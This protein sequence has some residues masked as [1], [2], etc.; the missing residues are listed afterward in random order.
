MK[1]ISDNQQIKTN[2]NWAPK[3]SNVRNQ[4]SCWVHNT[5]YHSSILSW[6]ILAPWFVAGMATHKK[7]MYCTWIGQ[8]IFMLKSQRNCGCK[9]WKWLVTDFTLS[10]LL[11]FS[12]LRWVYLPWKC[13]WVFRGT[14]AINGAS[15]RQ[16]VITGLTG[17]RCIQSLAFCVKCS[18]NNVKRK[19]KNLN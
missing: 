16:L 7:C 8:W 9:T 19:K 12:T 13:V 1:Y 18:D 4:P 3:H 10:W 11:S 14:A 2:H 17:P 6:L 5:P 15:W